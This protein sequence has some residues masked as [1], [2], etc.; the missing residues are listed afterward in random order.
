M[1]SRLN[2]LLSLAIRHSIQMNSQEITAMITALYAALLGIFFSV[3]SARVIALRGVTPLHWLAFNNYGE[4]ALKRSV[5]AHGNFVEY[6]PMV[7]VL[8]YLAEGSDLSDMRLH[9]TG[10]LLLVGRL[11]HGICFGF[12][13]FNMPLR[14]VGMVL[15]LAALVNISISLLIV[16]I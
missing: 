13:E 4:K 10:L 9:I 1:A 16:S 8:M 2:S 15:T 7:L 11:M 5:R 12:M 14:V 6:V 3:L